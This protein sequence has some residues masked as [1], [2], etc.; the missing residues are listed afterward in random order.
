MDQSAS[1]SDFLGFLRLELRERSVALA[2]DEVGVLPAFDWEVRRDHFGF[3]IAFPV[4]HFSA[5]EAFL[6]GAL[7]PAK[8]SSDDGVPTRI[9]RDDNVGVTVMLTAAA[10]LG[11]LILLHWRDPAI[12]SKIAAKQSAAIEQVIED[13]VEDAT[14]AVL[15]AVDSVGSPDEE[16]KWHE[17]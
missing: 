5:I 15:Q 12:R 6:L 2:A 3:T 4:A 14:A 13:A 8:F 11:Q 9:H 1:T 10:D 16:A 7:G 17:A